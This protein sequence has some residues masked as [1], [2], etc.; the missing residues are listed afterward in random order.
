M[1]TDFFFYFLRITWVRK[2]NFLLSFILFICLIFIFILIPI[3]CAGLFL[4]FI[5][6]SCWSIRSLFF[7][8]KG[9]S[10]LRIWLFTNDSIW[11]TCLL[12]CFIRASIRSTCL[13]RRSSW[14]F[15]ITMMWIMWIIW[16]IFSL[17]L[18]IPIISSSCHELLMQIL[19]SLFPESFKYIIFGF[20]C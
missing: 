2:I 12:F 13:F 7:N 4:N 3:R 14:C 5:R 20:V 17:V 10:Y 1:R 8:F 16:L 18:V 11:S 6:I 9:V 15:T 19:L